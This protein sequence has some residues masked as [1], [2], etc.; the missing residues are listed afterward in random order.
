VSSKR[1]WVDGELSS[2]VGILHLPFSMNTR[3]RH[4]PARHG[5]SQEGPPKRS[6]DGAPLRVMRNAWP[7]PP[8][9]LYY[10]LPAANTPRLPECTVMTSGPLVL[11][12]IIGLFGMVS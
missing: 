11:P 10:F 9:P 1:K 5:L 4:F 6:L 2:K 12:A 8:A 3:K 7:G